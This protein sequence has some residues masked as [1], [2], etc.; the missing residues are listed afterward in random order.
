MARGKPQKSQ[1]CG[2]PEHCVVTVIESI[3]PS[4]KNT[5]QPGVLDTGK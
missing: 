2:T 1:R 4:P 5:L 3:F